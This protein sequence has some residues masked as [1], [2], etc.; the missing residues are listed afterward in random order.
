MVSSHNSPNIQL[1]ALLFLA[2]FKPSTISNVTEKVAIVLLKFIQTIDLNVTSSFLE[3]ISFIV[4]GNS[5]LKVRKCGI[6][7]NIH[8][9]RSNET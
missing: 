1:N 4:T 8:S 5:A 9:G 7:Y 6:S 3:Y 2:N